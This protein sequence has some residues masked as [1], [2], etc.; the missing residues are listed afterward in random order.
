[1]AV[2]AVSQLHQESGR[3]LPIKGFSLRSVSINSTLQIPDNEIGVEIILN[4]H[5][6]PLTS[7]KASSKWYE[8]FISS[9]SPETKAWTVNCSGRISV[10]TEKR[11]ESFYVRSLRSLI[12]ASKKVDRHLP[13]K[14]LSK[15]CRLVVG[16]KGLPN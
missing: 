14:K 1:M 11:G 10:E 8:F 4:I 3:A 15:Q 12:E 6:V 16:T 7:T 5:P 13:P 9:E 2:E